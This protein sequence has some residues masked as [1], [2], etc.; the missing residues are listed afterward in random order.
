M[1]LLEVRKIVID[2]ETITVLRIPNSN[3][4][5]AKLVK[6]QKVAALRNLALV[7][8]GDNPKELT[9]IAMRARR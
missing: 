9:D 2:G 8:V 6:E 7:I 3:D 1:D 5:R 4:D